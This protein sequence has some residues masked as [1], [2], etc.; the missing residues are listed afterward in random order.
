MNL[1]GGQLDRIA[2]LLL[3][4]EKVWIT[5]H[6]KSDGDG[7]GSEI[8]LLRA[9]R[10]MGKDAR[11]VNDT[12]VPHSLH[13]LMGHE[14]E[15]H[16]YD[17]VKDLPFLREA[18][19]AVVLDVGLAYRLGRLEEPF[20]QSG[21]RKICLDHHL[22]LDAVFTH[23][24]VDSSATST[25]EILYVL[26]K[27][28]G[29]PVTPDVAA[30]LF[31]SIS[32][33]S[34]NFAYER[35]TPETFRTAADLVEAGAN[36]YRVHLSLN[37]ERPLEEVRL[38]GEVIQRLR[39]DPSGRVA[40]SEVTAEMLRQYKINPM[41]MPTVVNIPLSLRGVEVALLF[42]EMAPCCIKVS[43]R[44]KGAVRVSDL[45]HRFN[46]G[47]HPLAAGFSVKAS[48]DEARTLVL[49]QARDLLGMPAR[50]CCERKDTQAH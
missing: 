20:L 12:C 31:A 48:L 44:S 27:T 7:I 40:H 11:V 38:E 5:T 41:E 17:P 23:S 43:A 47:G 35:C 13:F 32:V 16:V 2:R 29:A 49:A 6:V 50:G 26:L 4:S 30:P 39:I 33:D 42:V 25:G 24:L 9:L 15:I 3:E 46:G 28:M 14:G 21:A 45:A 10:A 22:D 18:D 8:A 1:D 34:G 36:P 37:W 19:T